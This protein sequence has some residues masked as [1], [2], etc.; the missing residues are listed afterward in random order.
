MIERDVTEAIIA[1]KEYMDTFKLVAKSEHGG[2]T[3][4]LGPCR[5]YRS[6]G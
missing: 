5:R 1:I 2:D 3:S 6:H 4:N